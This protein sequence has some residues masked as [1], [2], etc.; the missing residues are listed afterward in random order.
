MEYFEITNGRRKFLKKGILGGFMI[1][2]FPLLGPFQSTATQSKSIFPS[3]DYLQDESHRR[4]LKIMQ[5]YGGEFGGI[6]GGL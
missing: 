2:T 1:A 4:L 6:K 5:K 3:Y